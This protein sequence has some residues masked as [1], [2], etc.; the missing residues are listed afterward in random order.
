MRYTVVV[1]SCLTCLDLKNLDFAVD[2]AQDDF[3]NA[4]T[5][6][7]NAGDDAGSDDEAENSESD[8]DGS[9]IGVLYIEKVDY[10]S[11]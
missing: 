4:A 8:R 6:D 7:K 1:K 9:I 2:D 3:S 5:E 11:F 10:N